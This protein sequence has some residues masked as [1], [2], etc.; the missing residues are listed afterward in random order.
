MAFFY[1][2]LTHVGSQAGLQYYALRHFPFIQPSYEL[3]VGV[4][5]GNQGITRFGTPGL[6]WL[7]LWKINIWKNEWTN[8]TLR[9]LRLAITFQH[10]FKESLRVLSIK[11]VSRFY[12]RILRQAK[13]SIF[14]GKWILHL[15]FTKSTIL[16]VFIF[17]ECN[18]K[19]IHFSLYFQCS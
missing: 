14:R 15:N 17:A 5:S 19:Y 6:V 13:S 12:F 4:Q 2:S 8:T 1:A 18:W 11:C 3:K 7:P 9:T 16:F 10:H